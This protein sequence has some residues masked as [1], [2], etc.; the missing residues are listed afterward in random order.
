MENRT[1]GKSLNDCKPVSRREKLTVIIPAYNVEK[2]IKPCLKSVCWA[3]EILLVDSYSTDNTLQIAREVGARVIQHEYV[4][5]AKQK[6]WAIPQASN[7]WILLLDS[8]EVVTR[9]LKDEIEKLL[10]SPEIENYDGFGIARKHF[11]LGKWLKWGGRYPLYNIRLFRR[12]CR[13]EDRD[14]HAHIILPKNRV[15]EIAGDILHFSDPNLESFFSKF[16]RYSTYQA[17]YMKKF[18]ASKSNIEWKKFLTHYIY[19]KSI[20]KDY[21][22][23]I[24]LAPIFR[25]AYMYFFRLGFLDGRYGFLIA[26]LYAFQD[27]VSKTKYLELKGREPKSRLYIQK[28][29]KYFLPKQGKKIEIIDSLPIKT[30]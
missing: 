18:S 12:A 16:N 22:Y 2:I 11:F 14:V 9:T 28:W 20:I 24:P 3:D 27:Y 30:L 29:I 7:E 4:Y 17:N 10:A 25:F 15:K 8:D 19:A 26:T 13:Y 21:W 1:S 5:S 6:N 23:F